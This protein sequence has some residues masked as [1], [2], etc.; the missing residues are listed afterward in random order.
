M[1]MLLRFTL[2]II[3]EDILPVH[4]KADLEKSTVSINEWPMTLSTAL[5][6]PMS[7]ICNWGITPSTLRATV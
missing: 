2:W 3:S 6:R 7:S 4:I 5:C 1:G